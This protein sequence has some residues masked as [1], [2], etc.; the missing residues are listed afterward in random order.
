MPERKDER[1]G[2]CFD[3]GRKG[4]VFFFDGEWHCGRCLNEDEEEA[5]LRLEDFLYAPSN[6]ALIM[7]PRKRNRETK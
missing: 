2:A 6:F 5:K 7:G 4:R 3:C 1:D